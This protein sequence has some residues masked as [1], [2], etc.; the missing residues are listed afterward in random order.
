MLVDARTRA[1]ATLRSGPIRKPAEVPTQAVASASRAP[2]PIPEK[3]V[4]PLEESDERAD[5][6]VGGKRVTVTLADT[7]TIKAAL[8]GRLRQQTSFIEDR[9]YFINA[10]QHGSSFISDGSVNI[11]GWNLQVSDNHL[12]LYY[13]MPARPMGM[14]FYAADV[15]KRGREWIVREI[16]Q[17]AHPCAPVTNPGARPPRSAS[18]KPR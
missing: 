14:A 6:E 16:V 2:E 3:A 10:A 1:R 4:A 8:L 15:E 17:G 9:D 5:L 12:Q 18:C 7:E 13:R 11:A